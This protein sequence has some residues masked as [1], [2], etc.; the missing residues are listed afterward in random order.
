MKKHKYIS[1]IEKQI[2]ELKEHTHRLEIGQYKSKF[3]QHETI[4]FE[5]NIEKL[6]M[7]IRKNGSKTDKSLES[8]V[9]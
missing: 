2:E 6:E 5:D 8:K 7:L 1:N 9:Y 3:N 4:L